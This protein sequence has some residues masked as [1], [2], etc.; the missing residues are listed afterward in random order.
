M[1][2]VHVK[3]FQSIEDAEVE[4]SGLTVITGPNNSGKTALVRSIFGVF[5]NPR[6]CKY[7]RN[8]KTHSSVTLEFEDGKAVTW[9]KGEKV[10]RYI[11]NKGKPLEKVG[12]GVPEEIGQ[13]GIQPMSIGGV[14]TWP[15]FAHQF[16]GQVFLLDKPGSVLAEAIADVDRVGVLNEALRVTQSDQRSVV[17]ECK[18]RQSDVVKLEAEEKSFDG[19][20]SA[21]ALVVEAEV[22]DVEVVGLRREVYRLTDM[23][24]RWDTLGQ[25]ISDLSAIRT[26]VVPTD[27]ARLVKIEAAYQ[28]ASDMAVKVQNVTKVHE[29]NLA[30]RAGVSDIVLPQPPDL[31]QMVT[32]LS[33]LQGVRDNV[34]TFDTTLTKLRDT[35]TGLEKEKTQADKDLSDLMGSLRECPTC[36]TLTTTTSEDTCAK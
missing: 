36:G 9:E 19:L 8:G 10:N 26:V 22:L 17:A 3:N 7:V 27:T 4:V 30:A 21:A 28:W 14:D 24:Q 35:L 1:F 29:A 18:V 20:E 13:F 12:A 23:R 34:S 25:L 11:F 33:Y 2:T 6:G 32:E 15:Q 5:T 16:T 31:N